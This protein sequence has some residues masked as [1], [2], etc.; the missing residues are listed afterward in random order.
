MIDAVGSRYTGCGACISACPEGCIAMERRELGHVYPVVNE[1]KCVRCGRCVRSCHSLRHFE[2]GEFA[3][4]AFALQAKDRSILRDSSSGGAF[5]LL[6]EKMI[7]RG[8]VVYGSAWN[9]GAGARH[10]RASSPE[11]VVG[12]RRSKYVQS[13]TVGIFEQVRIDLVEGREVL[14]VGTPCQVAA[15]RAFLRDGCEG[16]VTA[17][18]VCHGVPS[19]AFFE[20][21]LSWLEWRAGKSLVEYNSRDKEAAG[22]SCLGSFRTEAGPASV[23]PVDDPYV[24]TFSQN[25]TFRESCYACPYAGPRRVGDLTLGDFWGVERMR[26]DLDLDGGVSVVLVNSPVGAC[27]FREACGERAT[28]FEVGFPDAARSNSNLAR[29]SV[30]PAEREEI[31]EAYRGGGFAAVAEIVPQLYRGTIVKNSIKRVV[32]SSVKRLIK[33]A[34]R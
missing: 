29:P 32:P 12:L 9:R 8:G 33:G 26:L 15:V 17:D 5:S 25:A 7:A 18:L 19:S 24:L 6:A 20:E 22:W 34:L 4:A 21:Y 3:G 31:V 23:L 28:T 30:R 27:L 16:L 10:M 14:F 2:R 1:G 11:D 13:D